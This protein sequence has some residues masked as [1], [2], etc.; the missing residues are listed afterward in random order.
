MGNF[1]LFPKD[2]PGRKKTEPSHVN[3]AMDT[4][5]GAGTVTQT[6]VGSIPRSFKNQQDFKPPRG[7]LSV[8]NIKSC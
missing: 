6:H 7:P 3:E 1:N 5:S 4:L 8:S 2:R